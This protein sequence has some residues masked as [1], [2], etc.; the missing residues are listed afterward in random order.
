MGAVLSCTKNFFTEFKDF[1]NRGSVLDL[2]V[3]LIVGAAFTQIVTSLVNDIF[4][5]F[6][7]L[8]LGS[9]N[10]ENLFV[11]LGTNGTAGSV[12]SE[13][14]TFGFGDTNS[15][16]PYSTLD[17]ANQAGLVTLNYGNF[18]NSLI[19]FFITA[20]SVFLIVYMMKNAKKR[21]DTEVP[22]T[23]PCP[24]CAEEIKLLATR[25]RFC[26]SEIR[27][28]TEKSRITEIAMLEERKDDSPGGF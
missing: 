20:I 22:T 28:G 18:L 8:A 23:G 7:G 11:V 6:L 5:P 17:Q 2:A 10:F 16:V 21:G 3:A 27:Y 13:A 25:C 15:D 12:S 19:V 14:Q 9:V 4:S 24:F 26:I 1:L